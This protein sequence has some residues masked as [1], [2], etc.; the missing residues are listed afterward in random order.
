MADKLPLPTI[1]PERVGQSIRENQLIMRRAGQLDN[2]SI[3]FFDYVRGGE[4]PP[5]IIERMNRQTFAG[6]QQFDPPGHRLHDARQ[7][8][9]NGDAIAQWVEFHPFIPTARNSRE[10]H[11]PGFFEWL[12]IQ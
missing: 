7:S 2:N 11:S 6:A 8:S 1:L 12:M 9:A 3:T 5:G 10:Q 4:T